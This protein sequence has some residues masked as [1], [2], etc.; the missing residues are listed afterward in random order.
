MVLLQYKSCM[1]TTSANYACVG[2]II[3]YLIE[4]YGPQLKPPKD[5][6]Q[7]A[8]QYKYWLHFGEGDAQIMSRARSI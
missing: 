2:V 8:L 3:D 1:S 5:D 4:K 7:N 6:A